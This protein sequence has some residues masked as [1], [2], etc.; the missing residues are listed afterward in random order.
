MFQLLVFLNFREFKGENRPSKSCQCGIFTH[1]D[2]S[3]QKHVDRKHN[4]YSMISGYQPHLTNYETS[5]P[6]MSTAFPTTSW[7]LVG[8]F[9]EV[10][11]PIYQGKGCWFP[12]SLRV[13]PARQKSCLPPTTQKANQSSQ[14]VPV[15]SY[16]ATWFCNLGMHSWWNRP[17]NPG[18]TNNGRFFLAPV[19]KQGVRWWDDFP[20]QNSDV[21]I[22]KKIDGF[23]GETEEMWA[24]T[25]E[26]SQQHL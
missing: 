6:N 23:G 17:W 11:S 1:D 18:E 15:G 10:S 12:H 19:A 5:N 3:N 14:S 8:K 9:R 2:I 21:N 4:S 25:L 20:K 13:G 16:H 22:T 7:P 26:E 24:E